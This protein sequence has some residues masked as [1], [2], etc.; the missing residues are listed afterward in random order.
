MK[1][2]LPRFWWATFSHS[3]HWERK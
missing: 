1:L 2:N 3:K